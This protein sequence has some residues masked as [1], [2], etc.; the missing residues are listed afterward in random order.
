MKPHRPAQITAVVVIFAALALTLS[1]CVTVRP[2][3]LHVS[4]PGGIGDVNVGL[5]LCSAESGAPSECGADNHT[6]DAQVVLA[7]FTTKGVT[8]VPDSFT[9]TPG[10]APGGS[11]MTFHRNRDFEAYLSGLG[12]EVPAD[13]EPIGYLSD[14]ISENENDSFEWTVNLPFGLPAAP[15]GGS[16]VGPFKYEVL[17]GWREVGPGLSPDRPVECV[18]GTPGESAACTTIPESELGVSDLKIRPA[19]ESTLF[20]GATAEIP[21]NLDF[22]SNAATPPNNFALSATTTLPGAGATPSEPSFPVGPLD[23]N[24]RFS[25][26]R[27]AVVVVPA[28]AKEGTYEVRLN[29]TT[30]TGGSAAG[31]AL[32]HVRQVKIGI[33]KKL[34]KAKGTATLTVT[35]PAAGTLT[36]SGKGIVKAQRKS[37]AAKTLKLA[38]KTK[39]KTKK[40]LLANG[41]VK[42]TAKVSFTPTGAAPATTSK[43]LNLKIAH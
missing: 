5:Q 14:V 35:V 9:A 4:Q 16:Y 11:P 40:R 25:G 15:D 23:S 10:P 41:R 26:L 19:A 33:K 13:M 30:P 32:L 12:G 2:G 21:F 31:I 43:P 6:G 37:T 18:N 38:V 17:Y 29:A 3:S 1:A 7:F 22:G 8:N 34:N 24:K 20:P 39:G 42:V 36:V 27:K 28:K